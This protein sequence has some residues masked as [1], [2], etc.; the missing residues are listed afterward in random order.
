VT[1]LIDG[2]K[3]LYRRRIKPLEEKYKFHEFNSALLTDTDIE[4]KPMVM[5]LGQYSTGKTTFIKYLL[6]RE[7][8]GQRIGPEPTTDRFMAIMYGHDERLIPGNAAAAQAD[9][10]FTA[11]SGY[12]IAF[13]NKFEVSTCSAPLLK[14]LTFIDTPGVLSGEKQ[15]IG[16]AYD[17]PEIVKWFANR[18][19]RILLL[20][21]AHK[22]DISDEFKDA[23][24]QLRGNDDKIRVVLNKA[25][26]I[27]NQQLMRVYGALM[28]SL[29]KVI[30]T[31]E[32]LRVYI[33]SFWDQPLQNTENKALFEA[34]SND[35]LA[36]LRSLPR[37]S[38]VRKVN[39]IVKRARMAK[40]HAYMVA[41]L[42][43][44]FG[45]FGKESTQKKLLGSLAAE[46][47]KVQQQYN[48]P[49]G[50]FP[51]L[52]LFKEKLETYEIHK[53]PKL[54]PELITGMEQALATELPK[55]MKLLP[56]AEHKA[57]DFKYGAVVNPFDDA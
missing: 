53:F 45:W 32:V 17:F 7:F 57:D 20:F 18:V 49:K 25:D 35:L 30:N 52:R 28:W 48:L 13:L 9:K 42:R 31:P 26:S 2:L 37:N 16:R 55:L 41:H 36:D 39:E 1:A 10:P 34:E 38:A 11:L 27:S 4:A 43:D 19:D 15:R 23:I 54:D 21:D 3:S 29:G 22:L 44:Q 51:N 12:G 14:Q 47:R 5:L 8:P 33:G 40:V 56:G 6:E 24:D 50:D 46:F